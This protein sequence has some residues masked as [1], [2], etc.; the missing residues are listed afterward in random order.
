MKYVVYKN[1]N[2]PIYYLNEKFEFFY[3]PDD[4]RIHEFQQKWLEKNISDW[5]LQNYDCVNLRTGNT[6]TTRELY[7]KSQK[8]EIGE[9]KTIALID[10]L[11]EQGRNEAEIAYE[12]GLSTKTIQRHHPK[13]SRDVSLVA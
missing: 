5:S 7:E 12:L 11:R 9:P 4:E 10:A 8:V 3:Y 1:I 6:S 13:Y 2:T